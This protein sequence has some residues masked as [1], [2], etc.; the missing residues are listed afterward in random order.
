MVKFNGYRSGSRSLFPQEVRATIPLVF[1]TSTSTTTT[2]SVFSTMVL[3]FQ[4][5]TGQILG[6]SATTLVLATEEAHTTVAELQC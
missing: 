4:A 5:F 2:F 6:L 1:T 3:K